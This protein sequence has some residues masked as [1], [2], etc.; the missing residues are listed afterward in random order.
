MKFQ[1]MHKKSSCDVLSAG[2]SSARSGQASTSTS[3]LLQKFKSVTQSDIAKAIPSLMKSMPQMYPS[4]S[5][6]MNAAQQPMMYKSG[7]RQTEPSM[8][9]GYNMSSTGRLAPQYGYAGAGMMT[10]TAGFNAA[11]MMSQQQTMP[12][13]AVAHYMMSNQ[14]SGMW[15]QQQQ[16]M[17]VT[18]GGGGVQ[19][20]Q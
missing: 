2:P 19:C 1:Q 15:P 17:Q 16:Q 11:G 20:H 8:P 18:G 7:G 10:Q 4:F 6:Q 9:L 12:S 5:G 14:Q 3:K 13:A